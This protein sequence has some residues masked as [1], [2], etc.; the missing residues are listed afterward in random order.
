MLAALS[1]KYW[2]IS[3]REVIREAEKDCVACRRRE[4]KLATQVMAPLP[5]IRL[6]ISLQPFT[7]P[8][9]DYAGPF[10]TIQG[11]SI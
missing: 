5:D 9:V 3:A 10:I 7:N 1:A 4:A 2:I 8:A 6:K 11:R